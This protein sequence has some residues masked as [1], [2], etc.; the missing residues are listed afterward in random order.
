LPLISG[1]R[2]LVKRKKKKQ[3]LSEKFM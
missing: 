1:K 3:N 2:K